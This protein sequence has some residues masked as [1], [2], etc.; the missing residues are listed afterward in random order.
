MDAA[1]K[2][3]LVPVLREKGFAGSF[4]HFRRASD[5]GMDLLTFQF[6][7]H[8]GGFIIEISSCASEGLTTH[9]GKHI[10]AKKATAWDLLPNRRHRIQAHSG[11]GTDSWFRFENEEPVVVASSVI[12]HLQE[13]EQW[14]A[15]Q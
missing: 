12:E 11:S 4:P 15:S 5:R 3:V 8:G 10:P 6:D 14:W 1:I 2:A 9:W 7:R 13:A